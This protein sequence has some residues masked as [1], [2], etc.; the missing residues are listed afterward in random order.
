MRKETSARIVDI[1]VTYGFTSAALRELG[2]MQE[3]LQ[4]VPKR[5][6]IAA[7][8]GSAPAERLPRSSAKPS[9]RKPS[10]RK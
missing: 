10:A 5:D 8:D 4:S 1:F 2:V 3:E 6:T 7:A 9:A